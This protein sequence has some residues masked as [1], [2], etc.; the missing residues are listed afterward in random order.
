MENITTFIQPFFDWLLQTTLIGSVVICLILIVQKMLGG[1]LGPRWCHA[2]WLVL[3]MRMILPWAPSSRISL[4]NLIPSWDRPIQIQQLSETTQQQEVSHISQTSDSSD[5]AL[6]E[7]PESIAEIQKQATAKPGIVVDMQKEPQQKLASLRRAL[8]NLWLAGAIVV[9]IYILVSDFALWRIVKR[10]SPL[11]NQEMLELF[12]E[13]KEQMVVQSLV[14]VVPS[15]QVR[16]PGLF[17][18]IRPRLLLPQGMLDNAT[19]QEMRYVFLHEL[20]HLRRSDIYLGWLT[21]LLQVLHWFNPL[22]WFAFYRMRMDRE[23]ACDAL[24][25]SRTQKEES[26]EYGRAIVGLLRRFSRSRP[27]PAMAGILENRSQLKRRI[28]M[29]TEFKK[30]SYQWSPLAVILIIILACVSLP[31]A[32]RTKA[33]EALAP[34]SSHTITLRQV[35]SGPNVDSHVAASPDGRYLSYVDWKTGDLA[36]REIATGKTR[37][38]TSKG[39]LETARLFALYS[40]IS[41]D[42]RLVAYSWFNEKGTFSLCVIGIDGSADRTLYTS[43]DHGAFPVCWSSDSKQVVAKRRKGGNLEIITI[44]VEQ[45]SV[46]LLKTCEKPPFWDEFCYSP[47]DRFIVYD[48][49]VEEDSGNYDIGVFDTKNNSETY[50]IKH[51]A[52]DKL[53][54]WFSNSDEILFLSDRAGSQDIWAVKIMDGKAVGSP[55]PVTR[56][57][58]QI[59]PQGLTHDGSLFF[60]RYTRRFTT[61]IVPFDTERV[62]IPAGSKRPLLGSNSYPAWSPDGES[63]AYV[64]EKG[65][66]RRLHI[67]SIKTGGERELAS[68]IE[69]RNPR[70]SPDGRF[71]LVPGFDQNLINKKGYRGGIYKIDVKNGQADQVV[72]FPPERQVGWARSTAEW[73]LDGKAIFYLVPN[74]IV[75]RELESGQEKQLYRSENLTRALDISPDGKTLTFCEETPD[76]ETLRIIVISVSGGEPR[77]L[78]RFDEPKEGLQV[79]RGVVWMLDGNYVLFAKRE[80]KGS[81]IWRASSEGGDPQMIMESSDA[82]HSLGVHPHSEELAYSTYIQEG[83]IWVMENFLPETPVAKAAHQPKFTKIQIPNRIYGNAQFSPDGRKVSLVSDKKLWIIPKAGQ[84]GPDIPGEPMELNTEDVPVAWSGHAWSAD[85]KWIAFNEDVSRENTDEGKGIQGIYIVSTEGGKPKKVYEN[86]R[87]ERTVNYRIGLSPRGKTL[88]FTS[89]DL[90]RK[91]QH[92]YTIPVDGGKP[93]RLVDFQARE[94]VFSPDGK[95]VAFVEDSN[96]GKQGGDLYVVVAQGGTP[97]HV[98]NAVNASSPVW[99][100]SGDMIAFLDYGAKRSQINLVHIREDGT[101]VDDKIQI[102]VPEGV[103]SV[104]CLA[105]WSPDNVIGGVF[106]RPSEIGLY[107]ILAKGGRAMQVSRAGGTPRWFPDSRRI[108]CINFPKDSKYKEAWHGLALGYFPAKGGTFTTIPLQSDKKMVI[109]G[110]G[111]GN[112]VSPDGKQIVFSG[113]KEK[114]SPIFL[115]NHIWTVPVEGG[116]PKRLTS[117]AEGTTHMYPCWSPDGKTISFIYAKIP[118]IISNVGEVKTDIY[119]IQEDRGEPTALTTKSD[120]V[121]FGPIAWSPDG[122]YIAY[123][124]QV[125]EVAATGNI[126]IVS[127]NGDRQSQTI[128]KVNEV[129]PGKEFAW[130]PDSRRIAFNGPNGKTIS[131]M[132]VRDGSVVNIETG[133]VNSDIGAQLDWSP[134]GERFVFVGGK[135]KRSEF[136]VMEN[137]LPESTAGE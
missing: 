31:D 90:E 88:A 124:S 137:F 132:S 47:N 113:K 42:N 36:V 28:T 64:T 18:F 92:I 95:M 99:S 78:C 58:G 91:E 103:A 22:V 86:Y 117:A 8:P 52:S 46:E 63:L 105:G 12:E 2:L 135:G 118:D 41:P 112:K 101:V 38:L 68:D 51:P 123:Y 45:G 108:G 39:N 48:F 23:L 125:D 106:D 54:G 75:R 77:E 116:K 13:C 126:R 56:D 104:W 100:P 25:L 89:V 84:L 30:K 14:V 74:G 29:I 34:A 96:L 134:D 131:I 1:R 76:E 87:D 35:C 69:V 120:C 60:S 82:V 133:L 33:S 102:D 80:E 61:Y 128:G 26:Q 79:P 3:L 9:G 10:E 136:W 110:F 67:R 20:A 65:D 17:G 59:T 85:G 115:H 130:S 114:K 44:S 37:H 111:A 71:I 24:V 32:M 16:S 40:V 7:R 5:V 55:R 129:H 122:N 66:N 107:T 127:I 19:R 83:A 4:V 94:P 98:A 121:S 53:L 11:V 27:L 15:D 97:K 21:S 50:L 49:P 109:P 43:E 62:E 73:S 119:I 6:A 70:W 81:A 93:K 57:I 72:G